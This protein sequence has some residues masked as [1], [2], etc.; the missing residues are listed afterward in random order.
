MP[1]L[2]EEDGPRDAPVPHNQ[3]EGSPWRRNGVWDSTGTSRCGLVSWKRKR[4]GEGMC[5]GVRALLSPLA[6]ARGFCGSS[7]RWRERE[8]AAS[9][10][11]FEGKVQS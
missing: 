1:S 11:I 5:S 10:Y 2:L 8:A 9:L 6:P 4:K 3:P 7:K